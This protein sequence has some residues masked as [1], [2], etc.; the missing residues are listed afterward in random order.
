MKTK[1]KSTRREKKTRPARAARTTIPSANGKNAPRTKE[2]R[3]KFGLNSAI[4]AKMLGITETTLAKWE[5]GQGP[6]DLAKIIRVKKILEMAAR[7]MNPAY[8]ATWITQP[9]PACAE[10]GVNAPL[11]LLER[12]DCDAVEDLLFYLGS[13]VPT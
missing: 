12:N 8:V 7:S 11:D 5:K 3:H 10:I 2:L 9:S 6:F 4:F 1:A 13:G